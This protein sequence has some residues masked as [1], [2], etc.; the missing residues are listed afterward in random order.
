MGRRTAGPLR[1]RPGTYIMHCDI[2]LNT[3]NKEDAFRGM[4]MRGTPAVVA[5][6]TSTRSGGM[7]VRDTFSDDGPGTHRYLINAPGCANIRTV[8]GQLSFLPIVIRTKTVCARFPPDDAR[9]AKAGQ[10]RIMA[11]YAFFAAGV[12]AE[13]LT[14]SF[15]SVPC[16]S[17]WVMDVPL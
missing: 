1:S 16:G 13:A 10:R 12:T 4:E 3:R 14:P 15:S 7:V 6:S 8:I 2:M 17:H 9:E 11:L 5:A